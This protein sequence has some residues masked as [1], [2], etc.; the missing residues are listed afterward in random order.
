MEYNEDKVKALQTADKFK[1][2]AEWVHDEYQYRPNPYI[3]EFEHGVN[4]G[5]LVKINGV[6]FPR[7]QYN[8]DNDTWDFT[9]LY[10]NFGQ[11]DKGRKEAVDYAIKDANLPYKYFIK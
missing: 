5:W 6:R 4:E 1:I 9:Y 7:P 8:Y 2:T 11:D 3:D 10:V